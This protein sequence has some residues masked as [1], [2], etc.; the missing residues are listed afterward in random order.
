MTD[1]DLIDLRTPSCCEKLRA[2]GMCG[3]EPEM[4]CDSWTKWAFESMTMDDEPWK[5]CQDRK[6]RAS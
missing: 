5:F 2:D 6:G 1:D 4:V 3:N